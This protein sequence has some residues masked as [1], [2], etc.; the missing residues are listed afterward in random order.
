MKPIAIVLA[1]GNGGRFG[2]LKQFTK[3]NNVPLLIHTLQTF[4]D[5]NCILTV[6]SQ[7]INAA[8]EHL[9]TYDINLMAVIAGGE[10]RQKSVFN[11]LT[12]LTEHIKMNSH[13]EVII[14]DACR[15]LITK[16]TIEK[17]INLL[18][19]ADA[20]VSVCKSINTA[21][22]FYN[23]KYNV[24]DR[25]NMYELLMPQFFHYEDL[26]NAHINAKQT[27]STDDTQLLLKLNPNAKI[28]INEISFWEGFKMTYPNDKKIIKLLL[29]EKI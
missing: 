15:P 29:K 23:N 1:G 22:N 27:N 28:V 20:V 5:Y 17:G 7:Y 19:Q 14:T 12:Y 24:Y 16:S 26:Y 13:Q 11:A 2:E 9:T 8:I 4:K 18:Y 3:I 21:C 25:T 10:T 6:P